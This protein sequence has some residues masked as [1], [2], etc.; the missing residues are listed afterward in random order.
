MI[1]VRVNFEYKY[2]VGVCSTINMAAYTNYIMINSNQRL[3]F[4]AMRL[5][6]DVQQEMTRHFFLLITLS[7]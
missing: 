2:T 1:N 7:S 3:Q 6:K 4:T 5:I